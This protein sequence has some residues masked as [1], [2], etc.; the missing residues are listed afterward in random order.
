V[1]AED[2]EQWLKRQP[3]WTSSAYLLTANVLESSSPIDKSALPYASS[4]PSVLVVSF[5]KKAMVSPRIAHLTSKTVIGLP[6]TSL[7]TITSHL[8]NS[9]SS[10]P[11]LSSFSSLIDFAS[12]SVMDVLLGPATSPKVTTKDF[13]AAPRLGDFVELSTAWIF[14]EG[15]E[16]LDGEKLSIRQSGLNM[17]SKDAPSS[18]ISHRRDVN[19]GW[20]Y[21][22]LQ[23]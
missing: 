18:S 8:P 16:T 21:R 20:I 10:T 13:L 12:A 22:L 9:S 23:G 14:G 4:L 15:A 6:A 5:A 7:R 11:L 2:F 3:K 17:T 1:C 19:T